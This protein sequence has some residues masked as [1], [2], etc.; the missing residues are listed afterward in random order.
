MRV[1]LS[2]LSLLA[3]L[4]LAAACGTNADGSPV[5]TDARCQQAWGTVSRLHSEGVDPE[6]SF[7]QLGKL[8]ARLD[9]RATDLAAHATAA[10][11]GADMAGYV[12]EWQGLEEV[13]AGL[14]EYDAPH[15]LALAERDLRHYEELHPSGTSRARSPRRCGERS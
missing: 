12:N 14:E 7:P 6:G 1:A 2:T 5:M 3:L 10:D 8:W 4:P 9:A 11:C 13:L 15:Q